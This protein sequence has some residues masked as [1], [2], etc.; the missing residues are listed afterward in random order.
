MIFHCRPS[1][2]GSYL[3]KPPFDVNGSWWL[4]LWCL[5]GNILIRAASSA[6]Q[7]RWQ[8]Q[9]ST[10]CKSTQ[11][12]TSCSCWFSSFLLSQSLIGIKQAVGGDCCVALHFPIW[13]VPKIGVPPVIIHFHG[14]FHYKPT[15]FGYAH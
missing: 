6:R 3:W 5:A 1:I 9:A 14:I 8:I 10:K 7:Q 13:G 15:I 12:L 11:I 4:T 2:F